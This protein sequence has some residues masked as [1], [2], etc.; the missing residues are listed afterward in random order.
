MANDVFNREVDLGTP[1]AAESTRLII[2]GLT[3]EDML[4][5]N[6][7]IQYSQSINR[8]WEVGSSK[9]F[10][11]AGRTQGSINVKRVV[12]GKGISSEFIR[13]YGDVCNMAGNVITLSFSAGCGSSADLGK[14]TASGVVINSLAYSVAA[15][16]MVVN[17]DIAMMFARL[18]V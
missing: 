2:A 7:S 10:F 18:E 9:T 8:L 13:K 12:G 17:E 6:V 14:V 3:D 11:I 15:A 5:Q 4:A 16:D 1:L